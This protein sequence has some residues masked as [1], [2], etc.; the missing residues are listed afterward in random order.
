[1]D[2]KTDGVKQHF[3]HLPHQ[4]ACGTACCHFRPFFREGRIDFFHFAGYKHSRHTQKLESVPRLLHKKEEYKI[5][6]G[7]EEN[8]HASPR[9]FCSETC[10]CRKPQDGC[11]ASASFSTLE[12]GPTNRSRLVSST[13]QCPAVSSCNPIV[14]SGISIRSLAT[15]PTFPVHKYPRFHRKRFVDFPAYAARNGRS[16]WT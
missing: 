2:V 10:R 4:L 16:S 1:M 6:G 7:V 11:T 13:C 5:T 15:H 3:F 8:T 9:S 14:P 12:L